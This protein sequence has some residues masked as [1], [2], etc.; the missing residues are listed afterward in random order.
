MEKR[1]KK[2]KKPVK[3]IPENDL[4]KTRKYKIKTKKHSKMKKTVKRALLVIL[5][6]IIIA[7][8]IVTPTYW[9]I[10]FFVLGLFVFKRSDVK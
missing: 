1:I 3:R 7:A 2:T 4:D 9:A 10:I 8:G 6:L 5:L